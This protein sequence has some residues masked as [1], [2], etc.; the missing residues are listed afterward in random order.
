M[1]AAENS[2]RTAVGRPFQKGQSGNPGGRPKEDP[3][4]KNL[5][6]AHT[7]EAIATLVAIMTGQRS[8]AS[9]RVAAANALLDRGYGKPQQSVEL[10]GELGIHGKLVIDG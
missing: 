8:P 4:L 2:S 9:A 3:E 10:G 7:A 6:R 1:S 5:A